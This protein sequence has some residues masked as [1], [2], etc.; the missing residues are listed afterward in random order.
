LVDSAEGGEVLMV[1][2]VLDN[3]YHSTQ[4]AK[5]FGGKLADKR[6]PSSLKLRRAGRL[7]RLTEM[8][9]MGEMR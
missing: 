7:P 8:S 3:A 6:Y 2:I 5:N 1:K 4:N 9:N